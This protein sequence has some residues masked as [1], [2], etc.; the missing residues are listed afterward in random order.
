MAFPASGNAH[1]Q[2][3]WYWWESAVKFLTGYIWIPTVS[4]IKSLTVIQRKDAKQ[5][6]EAKIEQMK[7]NPQRSRCMFWSSPRFVKTAWKLS[8]SRKETS[9]LREGRAEAEKVAVHFLGAAF[10]KYW[11]SWVNS[12]TATEVPI[13]SKSLCGVGWWYTTIPSKTNCNSYDKDFTPSLA[14]SHCHSPAS[15]SL[16]TSQQGTR[17]HE[18]AHTDKTLSVWAVGQQ[19]WAPAS[20]GSVHNQQWKPWD[21]NGIFSFLWRDTRRSE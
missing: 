12:I 17:W 4:S 20:C 15:H 5:A 11:Q 19:R 3:W 14:A 16:H 1:P 13:K 21:V 8:I 6:F 10:F 2:V 9:G 18:S 7:N